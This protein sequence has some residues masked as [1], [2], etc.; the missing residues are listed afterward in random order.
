MEILDRISG[1]FESS[2]LNWH[3]G[4]S[5]WEKT[6]LGARSNDIENGQI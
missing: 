6:A 3:L 4:D 2:T 1:P 5:N